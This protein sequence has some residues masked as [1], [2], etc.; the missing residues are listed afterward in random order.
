MGFYYGIYYGMLLAITRNRHNGTPRHM[1]F[2]ANLV[3]QL[4]TWICEVLAVSLCHDRGILSAM[5]QF[6]IALGDN[7]YTVTSLPLVFAI[8]EIL[9]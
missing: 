2:R 5:L 3:Y 7:R 1:G 4:G 8:A 9:S 6:V